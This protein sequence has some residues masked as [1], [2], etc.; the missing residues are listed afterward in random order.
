MIDTIKFQAPISNALRN[1]VLAKHKDNPAINYRYILD[2]IATKFGSFTIKIFLSDGYMEM[3]LSPAKHLQGHNVFGTN[4]LGNLLSGVMKLIYAHFDVPYSRVVR[5]V[6]KN[7]GFTILRIDLTASFDVG[8]QAK[9]INTMNLLRQHLLILGH[10]VVV[11]VTPEGIET[12]YVGKSSSR[13]SVKFYNKYLELLDKNKGN[14]KAATAIKALPYYADVLSY[15]EKVVRFEY[16]IRAQELKD[17]G[18][19]SSL[20]WDVSM[21]RELLEKKLG[22]LGL[23]AQLIA[24]LPAEVVSDLNEVKRNKYVR[25]VEGDKL[26]K[27]LHPATFTRDRKFF[28]THGLDIAR[29][30]A[31]T[32]KGVVLTSRL[33]TEKMRM[34]Y[35]TRFV[36]TGAVFR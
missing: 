4:R 14:G 25:W 30:H 17:Q 13:S 12:V 32:P 9:V 29:T 1:A 3:E 6:Y 36:E 11:H 34:T 31:Q 19:K 5:A 35:P 18:R 15:A 8:S 16:T 22:K 7:K 2:R 20:A 10:D 27:T 28:L 33:S 24:E 23:S 21:V 26:R